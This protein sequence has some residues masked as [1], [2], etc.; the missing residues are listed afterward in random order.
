M[1]N[2]KKDTPLLLQNL[3]FLYHQKNRGVKRYNTQT[4]YVPLVKWI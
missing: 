1:N 2:D 4:I 3:S